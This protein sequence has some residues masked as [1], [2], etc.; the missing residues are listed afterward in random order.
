MSPQPLLVVEHEEDC[1]PG[2]VG[3]RLA[4]AGL[5]LDVCRPY[6]GGMLPKDLRGHCGMLVLG[7]D[8]GAY[9]DAECPWLADVK[10]L[11]VGAVRTGTPVLGICLGHQL[12]AV[13][14]G[15]QV[16]RNPLGQQ[17]GVL[18]VGWSGAARGDP[19]VGGLAGLD[20]PTPAVHW[21][22][23]IVA[24]L[25]DGATEL[26]R[27]CRGELQAARFAATVWGV[28]WHPEAGEEIIGRWAEHDR[29]DA[30]ERGVDLD[31]YVADVAAARTALRGAGRHLADGF[32][33]VC[34]VPSAVSTQ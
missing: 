28:Q 3:E 9:D 27:T 19:L 32:A 34:Q 18:G 23:D 10:R 5:R 24:R 17:V 21:N 7:G 16:T 12:V 25:P 33:A 14:L 20:A 1:P 4:E 22:N 29:D 6:A 15:G 13:A 8:M 30:A 31:A 11:V 2:W 26:A